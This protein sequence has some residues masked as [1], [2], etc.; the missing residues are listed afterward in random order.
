MR[1]YF[2]S[3]WLTGPT[4]P[5]W[6][7]M[8]DAEGARSIQ[9]E[10]TVR[11]SYPAVVARGNRTLSLTF[12][13]E[14]QYGTA[15]EAAAGALT[16]NGLLNQVDALSIY[17]GDR[18][19]TCATA[20]LTGFR[21][22]EWTGVACRHEFQFLLAAAVTEVDPPDEPNAEIMRVTIDIGNGVQDVTVAWDELDEIPDSVVCQ[23]VK[24]SAEA[25]D[26][27]V[28]NTHSWAVDGCVA[29]LN[30]PAPATGY[31]LSVQYTAQPEPVT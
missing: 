17:V 19:W 22:G 31:T 25:D 30:A 2:G 8:L 26:I 16:L 29:R 13:V 12:A 9:V 4:R 6:G 21:A 3:T 15:A 23:V 14:R 20:A 28:V 11:G 5:E 7:L 27:W 24:P 18:Q 1:V 10:D